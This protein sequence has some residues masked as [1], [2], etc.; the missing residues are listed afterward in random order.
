MFLNNTLT[1]KKHELPLPNE[2]I[3]K[4][5]TC[6][7]TVYDKSH[8]GHARTF[9]SLDIMR[10]VMIRMG[11]DILYVMNITDI[12][13]KIINRVQERSVFV[14]YLDELAEDLLSG[15]M[16]ILDE[17]KFDVGDKEKLT[18]IDNIAYLLKNKKINKS[19]LIKF[20][21]EN[22]FRKVLLKK[23]FE[24]YPDVDIDEKEYYK[25]VN[26]MEDKFWDDMDKLD[27]LRPN[28]IT[29][30]TQYIQ[31]IIT[32]IEKIEENGFAYESN[33][34]VYFDSQKFT[35]QGYNMDQFG[36]FQ[37]SD[38]S[39]S[40]FLGEKKHQSD[41]V[42]WKKAKPGEIKF[43]SKWG[44]GRIGW[45]SE[46]VVMAS[47]ILG[48]HFDIHSGGIDLKFPHHNNEIV[49]A[50]AH[51]NNGEKWAD[52]FLH[53][54]HLNINGDKMSKSLFNFVTIEDYFKNGGTSRQLR[55]LF[56]LHK[57][58]SPLDFN[59]E[60]FD[61]AVKVEK[62]IND[63]LNTLNYLR[64]QSFAMKTNLSEIDT[65]FNV[66]MFESKKN[67][68]HYLKSN[69][70]TKAVMKQLLDIIN[71]TNIYVSEPYD[72]NQTFMNQTYNY[73]I[74]TLSVFGLEFNVE[75]KQN[76]LSNDKTID[77]INLTINLRYDIRKT[78]IE[79]NKKIDKEV[80][81]QFFNIIDD[82]RDNKIKELGVRIE[83]KGKDLPSK[84]QFIE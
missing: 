14:S 25:L 83:D 27:I 35:E 5:Y 49:Q 64:N 62:R 68:D 32:Y 52:I 40:E 56:L 41:F 58:D 78:L 6:G 9:I 39:E 18:M 15:D 81:K 13:D 70:N 8:L 63:F 59:K 57:W 24:I 53:I 60:T 12:D 26:E 84:W 31:K 46:C 48:S 66:F 44:K 82:Y 3:L 50:I 54:G 55:L 19:G 72:F 21:S 37:N 17:L 20:L 7:P 74:S 77:W 42:L 23:L 51:K 73:V 11:Y 29:R 47:D 38:F 4:W 61:E 76:D 43:D 36:R 79:N 34:S 71:K 67:I 16:A 2:K 1:S 33:G 69:I 28:V 10:R 30:A 65:D 22:M 75:Q 45:H 80:F